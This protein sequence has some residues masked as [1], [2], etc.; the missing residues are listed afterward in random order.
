[1]TFPISRQGLE[2]IAIALAVG[3]AV[4]GLFTLFRWRRRGDWQRFAQSTGFLGV[5]IVVTLGLAYTLAPNIPT[6]AVPFTARF[7]QNPTPDD[8]AT[9]A[10][11]RALYQA[12]CVVCHG[13]QG[14]GDGPAALTLNPRPFNLQVHVPQHAPGEIEYWIANGIPFTAMPAWGV[15]DPDTGKPKLTEIERWEIVR[16]LQSLAAGTAS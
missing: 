14:L 4:F 9:I 5:L 6:P 3:A 7:A 16:F 1:V 12:N 13:P 2:Q 8:P 10:F 15:I 11:G